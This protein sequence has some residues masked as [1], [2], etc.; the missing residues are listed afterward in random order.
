M[1]VD[2]SVSEPRVLSPNRRKPR[3]F[4]TSQ[5]S[6]IPP[7]EGRGRRLLL[8]LVSGPKPANS[9]RVVCISDTHGLHTN[10]RIPPGDILIHAGDFSM[11]GEIEAVRHFSAWLRSLPHRYKVVIA[12]NHDVTFE[13]EFYARNWKR[14]HIRPYDPVEVREC[15][16]GSCIYLQDSEVNIEGIDI[17]GTP[18][19]PEFCNWAFNLPR[20][21][22]CRAMW[23]V[24]PPNVDILVTHSPP[25]GFGDAVHSVDR[26]KPVTRTGCEDLLH[27]VQR[28]V[29][30]R[31]H[32]FGHVHE[33][34]GAAT[35]G[36]TKYINASCCTDSYHCHNP[37]VVFDI[38]P[39]DKHALWEMSE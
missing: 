24:I 8:P 35:D 34:Y 32:V 5:V 12:G 6:S 18:W 28:R 39:E 15:L 22:A 13:P 7:P 4:G 1:E 11:S 19:Q 21:S 36:F 17:Y 2:V 27:T 31:Y 29:R 26:S 20:G 25:Y 38:Q 37:P 23:Q 9:L 16:R 3:K 14:F 30:P 33:G 10:L